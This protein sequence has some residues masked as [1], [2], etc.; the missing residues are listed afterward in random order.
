[1]APDRRLK[2]FFSGI[3]GSGM[4]AIAAF[5]ADKGHAVWGS[6]R[7]FD[8]DAF[9]PVYAL[10]KSKNISIVPQDGMGIDATFDLAVF[11]TAVEADRPEVKRA[12]ELGIAIR[13]RPEYLA[14][15]VGRYRTLA[16][17]G[18]S[19]K[20]TVSGM[21]AFLMKRLGLDPN[22]IGGGRVK[23]LRTETNPGNSSSG[24]SDYLVMEACESDGTIVNYQPLHSI[25]LNLDLDHNPVEKTAGMFRRLAENTGGMV[26]VNA[27]DRNLRQLGLEAAVT[28]SV[29]EPSDYKAGAVVYHPLST[30]FSV[31]GTRF[32][33]AIPGRYN[34]HNALASVAILSEMGVP[35]A[36]LSRILTEFTGLERRFEVVLDDGV[37]LVVDDYAHNPHKIAALMETVQ[38]IR[39]SVCY[40]F[41]PHGFGP[42]LMMKDEYIAA[43]RENL[44]EA[45]HLVLLPVFYAGGT[46][47]R[48][49]SSHDLADGVRAGGKSAEAVDTRE[50]AVET[51][52]RW[53][54]CVV[55][56]ARDESLSGLAREIARR[57]NRI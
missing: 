4:S 51:A 25:I 24:D 39:Q 37:R 55:L 30:S 48:D 13:S 8:Q 50:K 20:S 45:D 29:R 53:D 49:I 14:E 1:L 34:V 31:R 33:L 23:Q 36:E 41:Q 9:H 52:V 6:D 28:F 7:A 10:L 57:P 42:T 19:G 21:L 26:V 3:G 32:H 54:T 38:G 2:I 35:L 15:L 18:T 56:G 17:A 40:V 27:D 43:F 5:M 46:V 47:R 22:F 44:R 16:V 12:R 11:S